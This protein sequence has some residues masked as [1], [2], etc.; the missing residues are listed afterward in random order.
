MKVVV[1][2]PNEADS[3]LTVG[4]LAA[5]G[6]ETLV[7]RGL[8]ELGLLVGTAIGCVVVVEEA[9]V[10]PQIHAFH[11]ALQAQPAWSDLPIILIA[12]G[13]RSL[14]TLVDGVF[15]RSGNVT[16]LQRPLHPITLVSAVNVA[17]RS[18]QRQIEVRD[19]LALRDEAV[20]QRDEFLA[21][22]AH[23]LRNPLAPIR[24]AVYLLGTLENADPLFLKCRG[25]IE[26]Q[27]RHI[28]R[29]VDDLLDVSRLE[30]GKV[31]LRLQLVDL[32]ESIA[33]AV[34]AC[35]AMTASH[36]HDV[37][38]HPSRHPLLVRADPVRL[39][40]VIGNLIVNAAKFTPDGG[41]ID[42]EAAA[43]GGEAV[44]AV[45]DNGVGIR[46]EM[47]ESI[48]EL[49]TQGTV[50]S[51]R[52]DGGLGIGLTVVKRLMELHGGSVRATSGGLGC[53]S[54]FEARLPL[55]PQ[56]PRSDSAPPEGEAAPPPVRILIVEDRADARDSLGMLIRAWNH[57]VIYAANGPEGLLRA[58]EDQ[59]DVVLIY[60]G[61]PGFDGYQVARQIRREGSQWARHVRLIAVTGYGQAADR[62]RA[63]DAGFDVHVL[64]PVDPA[65]L[66]ELLS[67]PVLSTHG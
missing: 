67:A 36:R 43:D 5:R 51:A 58:R 7:C 13:E 4:F 30:R 47:L 28:S 52:T 16:V 42:V 32:N 37:R 64:K 29:L 27:S 15:P 53:G 26:K 33:S 66:R 62:A 3:G 9:L 65:V 1:V 41:T 23:E 40:Q 39:E 48:F 60:I 34:E 45:S 8:E 54:R 55:A 17:L 35:S 2:T 6:M 14:S 12:S 38:L 31:E 24:N 18:R 61:L 63:I 10:E 59:P 50:S 57:E 46:G 56:V 49:F 22:L 11:D 44:V 20:R 21:M 25:M 19:L